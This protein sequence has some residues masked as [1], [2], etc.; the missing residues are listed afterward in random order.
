FDNLS[1]AENIFVGAR[2]KQGRL[3]A[4]REMQRRAAEI[5][6]QLDAPFAPD[7]PAGQLSV[8]QKHI[9]QIA[10]ALTSEARVLILDEPTAA[11]SHREADDLFRIVRRLKESGCALLFI[12]HKFEEI[13]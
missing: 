3:V 4:W 9:V 12:S 5:L 6:K 10:R 7:T 1:V 13:F 2:P 11:L 8:A